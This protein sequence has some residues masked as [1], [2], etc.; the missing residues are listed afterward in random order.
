MTPASSKWKQ[1]GF[2]LWVQSSKLVSFP[3]HAKLVI[4]IGSLPWSKKDPRTAI[5]PVQ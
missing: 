5:A 1:K 3:V 4:C 2:L